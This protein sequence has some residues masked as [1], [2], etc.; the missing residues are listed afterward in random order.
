MTIILI[1]LIAVVKRLHE[2]LSGAQG[3]L[4]GGRDTGMWCRPA[5]QHLQSSHM[6]CPRPPRTSITTWGTARTASHSVGPI[7]LGF[8]P[9]H[10]APLSFPKIT[11]PNEKQLIYHVAFLYRVR[12]LPSRSG[13]FQNGTY[14]WDGTMWLLY[15]KAIWRFGYFSF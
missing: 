8:P 13:C 6:A 2:L 9:S 5:L 3:A 7:P 12:L 1:F 10:L 11:F 4:V 15:G 14:V